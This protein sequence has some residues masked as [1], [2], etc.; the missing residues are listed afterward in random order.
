MYLPLFLSSVFS[1][2]ALGICADVR[3][4]RP[5]SVVRGVLALAPVAAALVLAGCR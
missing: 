5:A 2:A 3:S 1:L 4:V